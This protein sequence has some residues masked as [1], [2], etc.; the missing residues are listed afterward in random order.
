MQSTKTNRTC[1]TSQ[2]MDIECK[3]LGK[4]GSGPPSRCCLEHVTVSS[5]PESGLPS[6]L[7]GQIARRNEAAV[8]GSVP[9]MEGNLRVVQK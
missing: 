1:M 5:E 7:K 8:E 3:R 2:Q 4:T 9:S 6:R